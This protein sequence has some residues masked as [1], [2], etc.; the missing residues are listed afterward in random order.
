MNVQM[1]L[2][3]SSWMMTASS[4]TVAVPVAAAPARHPIDSVPNP[5]SPAAII[6]LPSGGWTQAPVSHSF[7]RQ[8]RSSALLMSQRWSE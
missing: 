6:H 7:S 5:T 3:N 1:G 4:I 2:A 8:N